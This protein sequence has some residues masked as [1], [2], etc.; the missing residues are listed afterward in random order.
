MGIS[1][2][3]LRYRFETPWLVL[4]Q[5]NHA[6]FRDLDEAGQRT[7]KDR[8]LVGHLLSALGGLDF[9]VQRGT[10]VYAAFEGRSRRSVRF[11]EVSFLGAEGRFVTNV[12]LP[13]GLGLG[14]GSSHGHGRV[15]RAESAHPRP[16]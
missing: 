13:D 8:I 2:R 9:R 14:K 5:D 1:D 15:L 3:L 4:N 7:E 12:V 16:C 6:R 10:T 11:K